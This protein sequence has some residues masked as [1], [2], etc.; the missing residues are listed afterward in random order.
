MPRRLDID[1]VKVE[2]LAA[3]GASLEAIAR[4]LGISPATLYAR[5]RE[6]VDFREAVEKGRA[7]AEAAYANA[8]R[9][10]ALKKRPD[11]SYEYETK[12]RIKALTF[13]LERRPGWQRPDGQTEDGQAAIPTIKVKIEQ[14]QAARAAAVAAAVVEQEALPEASNG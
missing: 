10:I 14:E 11:G 3:T 1:L 7:Q 13:F 8:L 9:E 6:S 4:V 2:K 12:H 5:K